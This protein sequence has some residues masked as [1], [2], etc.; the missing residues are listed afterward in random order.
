MLKKVIIKGRS[1]VLRPLSLKD[2][3]WFCRWLKDREVTKFL[4][5]YELPPPALKEEI[6]WIKEARRDKNNFRLAIDTIDGVHIGSIALNKIDR[7]TKR[8]EF[9]IFIGDKKYHGQGLGTEAGQLII[10]YGFRK[11]KLHRIFLRFVAYNFRGRRSYEKLGFELEGIQRQH[12]FRNGHWHD[13]YL[14]G[15]LAEEWLKIKKLKK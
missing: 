14:M 10:N 7:F 1:V 11:L 9:G 5:I 8:A 3:P 4:A 15:I 2:A 12:V 13:Q 6:E